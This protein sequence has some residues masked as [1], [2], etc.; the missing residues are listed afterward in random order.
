MSTN[1]NPELHTIRL[2][3][4]K[5]VVKEA[6]S[7]FEKTAAH[8][9]LPPERFYGAGIYALYYLGDYELYKPIAE[10]NQDKIEYPIYIGKAVPPGSRTGFDV[11]DDD[12][13]DLLGRLGE[14]KKSLKQAVDLNPDDFRCR[15]M[16]MLENEADL[17]VPVE[18]ALIRTYKPLW[19]AKLLHGFGNHDPGG[20][21]YNQRRSRWDILH[22]GRP[23]AFKMAKL[24]ASREDIIADVR[25]FL[26]KLTSG[27]PVSGEPASKKRISKKHLPQKS[28]F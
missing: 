8:T 27:Q 13:E 1:F 5:S 25:D 15:F 18:S 14:H 6:I 4:L 19:N 7:F 10:R 26:K 11:P 23:W 24:A 3:G 9:L 12:T 22:E 16:I 21:R 20:G 2:P 28:L 17:I